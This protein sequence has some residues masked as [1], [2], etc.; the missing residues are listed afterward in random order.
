[1]RQ[2]TN[3]LGTI[4]GQGKNIAQLDSTQIDWLVNLAN[5]PE[6]GTAGARA[7]NILCFFYGIC[8]PPP[9]SPKSNTVSPRK[10]KPEVEDLMRAQNKVVISPNPADQFVQMQYELLFSKSQ[11][12]MNI[13]DELGRR[14]KTYTLGTAIQGVEVLD[15]RNL[16]P[17][18][19]IVEIVQEG[20]QVFSDKFIVQH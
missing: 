16:V 20:K 1:M 12:E 9:P 8:S 14:V 6:S 4:D 18:L 17:G 5:D 11:T 19:Y 10:P 13:Y 15:T 2:F 7:E 3:F